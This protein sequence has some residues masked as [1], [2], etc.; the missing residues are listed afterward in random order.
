MVYLY[1]NV[2]KDKKCDFIEGFNFYIR[3]DIKV[4]VY[5]YK[6]LIKQSKSV[7]MSIKTHPR[8][9]LFIVGLLDVTKT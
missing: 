9:Q 5:V 6:E 4:S 2:K 1:K 3:F 8:K 7:L